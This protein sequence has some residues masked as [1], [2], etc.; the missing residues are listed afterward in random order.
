M[1]ESVIMTNRYVA[2][3]VD[4]PVINMVKFSLQAKVKKGAFME[5]SASDKEVERDVDN[6]P[7]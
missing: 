5:V 7:S 1:I 2:K 3:G 6:K 4:F